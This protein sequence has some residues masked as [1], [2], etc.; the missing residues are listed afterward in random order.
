MKV[1]KDPNVFIKELDDNCKPFIERLPEIFRLPYYYFGLIVTIILFS[2]HSIFCYIDK[3][4]NTLKGDWTFFMLLI[5]IATYFPLTIYATKKIRLLYNQ[6]YQ[7]IDSNLD[8]FQNE[9]KKRMS[10]ISSDILVL[11]FSLFIAFA[12][13][14]Y[15]YIKD[16]YWY[17]GLP[18]ISMIIVFWITGVIAG[19]GFWGLIGTALLLRSISNFEIKINPLH[20]DGVGGLLCMGNISLQFTVLSAI[21]LTMFLILNLYSPWPSRQYGETSIVVRSL[22]VVISIFLGWYFLWP[23]INLHNKMVL[24]KERKLE[25]WGKEF[26]KNTDKFWAELRE[27]LPQSEKIAERILILSNMYDRILEVGEWPFNIRISLEVLG[28]IFLLLIPAL[29]QPLIISILP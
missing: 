13:I 12:F 18:I 16:D 22:F 25:E 9:Y 19:Y 5:F 23:L 15:I 7:R 20:P 11:P 3:E 4:I 26:E 14:S 1:A 29:F 17:N 24:E 8:N 28:S 6:I 2:I 21:A 27:D 10:F